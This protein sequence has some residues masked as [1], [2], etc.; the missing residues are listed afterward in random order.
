ML[1]V[2]TKDPDIVYLNYS[3]RFLENKDS[4]A[5][6]NAAIGYIINP[7]QN[8]RMPINIRLILLGLF[9]LII[10]F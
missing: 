6:T 1:L 3:S 10:Q 2:Q 4:I 9:L 5:I 7:I 8:A